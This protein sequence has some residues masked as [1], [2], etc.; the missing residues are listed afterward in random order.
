MIPTVCDWLAIQT[1]LM[2]KF[3]NRSSHKRAFG[4]NTIQFQFSTELNN[5]KSKKKHA[6]VII[7]Q[8]KST[9][10][11]WALTNHPLKSYS[12]VWHILSRVTRWTSFF[13]SLEIITASYQGGLF[14]VNPLTA[15]NGLIPSSFFFFPSVWHQSL[16]PYSLGC[17]F[18]TIPTKRK[19]RSKKI[20]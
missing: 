17:S 7:S 1:S 19:R 14:P 16:I 13:Y 20:K 8:R 10:R 15:T 4:R 6:L 5:N 18:Q 12:I 9:F 2:G 11:M 3:N